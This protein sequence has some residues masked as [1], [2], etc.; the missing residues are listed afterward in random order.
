MKVK[1]IVNVFSIC[2]FIIRINTL[3]TKRLSSS[4]KERLSE[5]MK[6]CFDALFD[7]MK[8]RQ[9][10]PIGWVTQYLI[11]YTAYSFSILADL[12][13]HHIFSKWVVDIW[14]RYAERQLLGQPK[15]WSE[16]KIAASN[17]RRGTRFLCAV[18]ISQSDLALL[19]KGAM[20]SISHKTYVGNGGGGSVSNEAILQLDT[21]E[22][23]LNTRFKS[24]DHDVQMNIKERLQVLVRKASFTNR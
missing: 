8:N 18:M 9:L 7:R 2:Q 24:I 6:N 13:I 10:R 21:L 4:E 12:D 3:D 22:A 14:I 19:R 5:K 20:S 17:V 15:P 16:V 1:Q 11:C 23:F